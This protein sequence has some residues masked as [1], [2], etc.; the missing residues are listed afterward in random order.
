MANLICPKCYSGR[1][2]RS[3]TKNL[4]E[5][6]LKIFGWRVYRCSE[7]EC[8]WRGLVKRQT[9]FENCLSFVEKHIISIIYVAVIML[10]ILVTYKLLKYVN[11]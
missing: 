7:D 9:F 3:S 1:I 6:F 8:D 4:K 2:I 11:G 10:S 5:K